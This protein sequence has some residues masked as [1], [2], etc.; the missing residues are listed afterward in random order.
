MKYHEHIPENLDE[1]ILWY[2]SHPEEL[3]RLM[4]SI[5]DT[6]ELSRGRIQTIYARMRYGK[7]DARELSKLYKIPVKVINDIASGKVFRE[8][9]KHCEEGV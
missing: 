4:D 3:Q 7:A 9:T 5:D 1:R 6:D 8:I 2:I